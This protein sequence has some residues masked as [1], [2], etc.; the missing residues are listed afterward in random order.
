MAHFTTT[1]ER[2]TTTPEWLPVGALIGKLVNT[3]ALRNDLIVNLAEN[4]DLGAPAAFNPATCEIEINH[5]IAF[6]KID[7]SLIGDLNL[8]KHQLRHAKASGAILHEALHARFTRFSLAKAVADLSPA[9]LK[10]LHLLEEGR[11]EGNGIRLMPDNK[12]LLRSCAMEIVMGDIDND[13]S[14]LNS[15]SGAA[16]LAGITLARVDAGVLDED[17][18][19]PVYEVLDL[20][21]GAETLAKLRDIWRRFQAHSEHANALPL[22]E[23]AREW[24]AVIAERKEEIGEEDSPQ[25]GEGGCNPVPGD[26]GTSSPA[27]DSGKEG[28]AE[29]GETPAKKFRR[30][31]EEVMKDIQENID[32]NNQ[33]DIDDAETQ[34]DWKEQNKERQDAF[35]EKKEFQEI[36]Q[37]VFD[38]A[39]GYQTKSRSKIRE[40]RPAKPEERAAA[41]KIAKLIEKAKYRERSQTE[42]NSVTP[43]GRLRTRALVQGQAMKSKGINVQA[44][45]WRRTMRK[46]TDQPNL[47]IG[48]MVDI[49]GSMGMAMEPMAITAWVMSEVGRRVQAKTAMVYYGEDVFPTLKPG[50]HL[51]A[52][53]IW[54]AP[55]GTERFDKAFKALAGSMNLL[56]S[57]GAR[58]LVIVSDGCYTQDEV[59]KAKADIRKANDAGVAVLWVTFDSGV[60]I[61]RM[62]KGTATQV[63]SLSPTE[64][65]T[66]AADKI[67]QAAAKALTD[68][69]NRR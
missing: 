24:N 63:V 41:V 37:S 50:Q 45:P 4:A 13:L 23:L 1:R 32:I 8:R 56:H 12:V 11:I 66:V 65:P 3:W 31:L 7:P 21:L 69:S 25:P 51:N 15:V 58:L 27:G 30:I 43:P 36:A 33:G 26:S 48:V 35:A 38:V 42:V 16:W 67:G 39:D 22:Y 28:E 61:D 46:H 59:V 17:D 34:E 44:E 60:Y 62:I 9:D 2:A 49:S 68:V 40:S 54:T 47:N 29:K 6:G 64:S 19:E 57:D 55:D 20:Y 52:V 5:K 53:N 18:V 10:A 14:Q